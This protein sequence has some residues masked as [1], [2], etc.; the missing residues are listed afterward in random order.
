M[1]PPVCPS[2]K[3]ADGL[4]IKKELDYEVNWSSTYDS[5]V[6]GPRCNFQDPEGDELDDNDE[7]E[8]NCGW[9]GMVEQLVVPTTKFRVVIEVDID[10]DAR[11]P[12]DTWL[13]K[14]LLDLTAHEDVTFRLAER[15]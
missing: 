2:C 15:V 11:G 4:S 9:T 13:W 5:F 3:K 14:D 6:V 8:C 10:P 12:I 1:K 7:I